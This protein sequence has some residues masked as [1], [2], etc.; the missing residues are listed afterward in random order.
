MSTRSAFHYAIPLAE[1]TQYEE[2]FKATN[3]HAGDDTPFG[4]DTPV[5]LRN[6][7]SLHAVMILCLPWRRHMRRSTVTSFFWSWPGA[8]GLDDHPVCRWRRWPGANGRRRRG[9]VIEANQID[10]DAILDLQLRWREP[11]RNHHGGRCPIA[12]AATARRWRRR[13]RFRRCSW[14]C[15]VLN[16]DPPDVVDWAKVDARRGIEEQLCC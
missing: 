7:A 9:R 12:A 11:K 2:V 8:N 4:D 1:K 16:C 3:L 14:V 15:R 13:Q 10:A 5:K 6:Y